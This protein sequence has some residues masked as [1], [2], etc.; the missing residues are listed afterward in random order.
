MRKKLEAFI[1]QKQ[2]G[3]AGSSF[4]ERF[5]FIKGENS[6]NK[7][8]KRLR[9]C[10]RDMDLFVQRACKAADRKAAAS[11]LQPY[12]SSQLRSQSRRLFST[13]NKY[14]THHLWLCTCPSSQAYS[15]QHM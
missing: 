5:Q 3:T 1:E 7:H 11:Q 14:S 15:K 9:Q 4:W 10:N 2:E 12:P 8:L 6:R 13:L